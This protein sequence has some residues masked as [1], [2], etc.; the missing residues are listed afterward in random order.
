ME[1]SSS[2]L[3]DSGLKVKL[4]EALPSSGVRMPKKAL[5]G[6]CRRTEDT[7][8][9]YAD[10]YFREVEVPCQD[11]RTGNNILDS[12]AKEMQSENTVTGQLRDKDFEIFYYHDHQREMG[13]VSPD[14][15]VTFTGRMV[16][17]SSIQHQHECSDESSGIGRTHNQTPEGSRSE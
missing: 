1:T 6:D 5:R 3:Q 12:G 16:A 15:R 17:N 2:I 10:L 7:L 4:G 14:V 8:L 13:Q 11:E 9:A